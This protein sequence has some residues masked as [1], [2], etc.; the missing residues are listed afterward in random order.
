MLLT[1]YSEANVESSMVQYEPVQAVGAGLTTHSTP[2]PRPC[3]NISLHRH[4][5]ILLLMLAPPNQN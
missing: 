1:P 4:L 5:R 2:P 3:K